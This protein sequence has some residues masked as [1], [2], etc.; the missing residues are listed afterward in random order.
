[1]PYPEYH[2]YTLSALHIAVD[3]NN[4]EV[5]QSLLN[6]GAYVNQ[7]SKEGTPLYMVV[8]VDR[9][10]T[11]YC[12]LNHGADINAI[13]ND[14]ENLFH[15]FLDMIAHDMSNSKCEE[16]IRRL[17]VAGCNINHLDNHGN[18]PI[19]Y[20]PLRTNDILFEL[21][22]DINIVNKNK[23]VAIFNDYDLIDTFPEAKYC[24][25]VYSQ[26]QKLKFVQLEIHN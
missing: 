17:F 19:M 7:N 1:M 6:A 24:Y 2:F 9:S 10:E 15:W 18:P 23:N 14:N 21:G 5:I 8:S 4:I 16:W 25:D 12:L 22:A 20:A 11:F 13:K 3:N 26:I